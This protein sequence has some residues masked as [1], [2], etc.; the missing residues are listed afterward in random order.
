MD[1]TSY[2]EYICL[3]NTYMNAIT[4][5]AKRGHEFEGEWGGVY[6]RD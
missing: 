6:R 1:S 4:S 3:S 2:L 5:I